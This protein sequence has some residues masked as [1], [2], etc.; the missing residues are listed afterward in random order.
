MNTARLLS[1]FAEF[2]WLLSI[3]QHEAA[4]DYLSRKCG[5]KVR[6]KSSKMPQEKDANVAVSYGHI[7]MATGSPAEY[8]VP[9]IA[10]QGRLDSM[11][12]AKA[13]DEKS[14]RGKSMLGHRIKFGKIKSRAIPQFPVNIS[15]IEQPL[16]ITSVYQSVGLPLQPMGTIT[17]HGEAN[18]PDDMSGDALRREAAIRDITTLPGDKS[19]A[20]MSLLPV[21]DSSTTFVSDISGLADSTPD[22]CHASGLNLDFH[23]LF[24]GELSDCSDSGPSWPGVSTDHG[25][26][27]RCQEPSETPSYATLVQRPQLQQLP[28]IWAQVI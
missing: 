9:I 20:S 1:L 17:V 4:L 2:Y 6:A 24:E 5:S 10:T 11:A 12:M 7:P 16:P 18:N 26:D 3:G 25:T 19:T 23:E 14:G 15:N 28:P 13:M 22:I 27:N 8:A 21:V